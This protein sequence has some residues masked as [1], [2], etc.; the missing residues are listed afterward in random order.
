MAPVVDA[1]LAGSQDRLV[2]TDASALSHDVGP[3]GASTPA[4]GSRDFGWDLAAVTVIAAGLVLRVVGLTA[5]SLW[6]DETF[7]IFLSNR[8]IERVFSLLLVNEPHPPLHFLLLHLTTALFGASEA[9][10]RWLS[11]LISAPIVLI[12]WRFGRRLLGPGPALLATIM[13]AVAPSQVAAGQEARMY[14]LL[15]LTSLASWWTLWLAFERGERRP[16]TAYVFTTAAML[17]THYFGFF[18]LVSQGIYV[19]ARGTGAAG[20][21]RWIVA[22]AAVFVLFLPWLPGFRQQLVGG[23]TTPEIRLPLTWALP[24]DTLSTMTSGRPVITPPNVTGWSLQGAGSRGVAAL[25]FAAVVAVVLLAVCSSRWPRHAKALLLCA[26]IG[27]LALSLGVSLAVNIYAPRYMLF[28]VPPLALLV[29]AGV[30]TVAARGERWPVA[31]VALAMIVLLPNAIALISYYRQPRLDVFDWRLV[32]Q[33]L[34]ARVHA[35]DAIVFLPGF[36]RIPVNYYFRG[37]QPRLALTPHGDD[38]EGPM[39]MRMGG[40]VAFLTRHPRV[41]ILTVPPAPTSVDVLIAALRGKSYTMTDQVAVNM[42]RLV[43]MERGPA[44]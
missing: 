7:S 22:L 12:T 6:F 39:G 5:K 3:S 2:T 4:T 13:V 25:G 1:G 31:A 19:L 35:D 33:T 44:P 40:V 14:G 8:P 9:T 21:R 43:L 26:A 18:I 41:W 10:V 23:H 20:W 24:V 32:S 38:V 37:P 28:I 36:A 34:A 16:W 17:Y 15:T 30:S 42:A 29:G 27:P 11:V